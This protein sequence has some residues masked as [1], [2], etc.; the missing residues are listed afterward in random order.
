M[1][2]NIND[3]LIRIII[4]DISGV[5][6]QIYNE[7]Y[8]SQQE[9]EEIKQQYLDAKHWRVWVLDDWYI[10]QIHT[11]IGVRIPV[12]EDDHGYLWCYYSPTL[13]HN[14]ETIDDEETYSL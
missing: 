3:N 8:F 7:G 6:S 10:A 2:V 14:D 1:I 12:A 5:Y 4:L 9:I 11:Y 13:L